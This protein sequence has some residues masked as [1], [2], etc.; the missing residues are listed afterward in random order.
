[1]GTFTSPGQQPGNS[2]K[3]QKEGKITI[4]YIPKSDK[5]FENNT[6]EY[7]DFEEVKE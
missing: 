3:K 7:I 1:M 5:K 6:G 4:D 2:Q